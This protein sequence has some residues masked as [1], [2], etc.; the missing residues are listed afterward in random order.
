MKK[1]LF[2]LASLFLTGTLTAQ[3]TPHEAVAQMKRGINMG[4]TL[5][6]PY[7]DGWNN[8]PAEEY[9]FDL[10]KE[11]GFDVVRVPVR[12]HYHTSSVAPFSIDETWMN[13]VEEVVDWGLSR[14][15][16]VV[17]NA[18]HEEWIKEDYASATKRARFD[19]IWSQISVRFKDKSEKLI[20]E[21]INEPYGLSKVQNDELHQR[22]LSIIRRSN[23]TRNVIIQGHK[24][25]GSE[26]LIGMAIPADDYLIGSFH[27]YDPWPFGLEGTGTFGDPWQVQVLDQKFSDVKSWSDQ[28]N[29][30]VFLG[31]FGCNRL[32]DYNSRMNHYRTYVNLSLKYG[33][34][35]CAWDDGGS[36][37]ILFRGTG[38]WDEVKD[39]LIHCSPGSPTIQNLSIEQDSLIRI[40][41]SKGSGDHDSI[42]I[43]RRTGVEQYTRIAS[44]NPDTTS[45]LDLESIPNTYHH[46]RIIAH[47]N[48]GE[49]SHSHPQRIFL[50]EYIP[51]VR[52]Y[53]LGQAHQIPGTV[54]AEDFDTGGEG[55]AY[56]DMDPR[57]I[58][59][60]YRPDE[61]VDIY[62]RNGD[63]YHIGNALPGEWYEY[64]VMVE[65]EG[66]YFIDVHL[67][68]IEAHG[69]FLIAIGDKA[70]DTLEALNSNSWLYTE[71]VSF[72]MWLT[73]G[74]QIMRFTVIDQPL[75]NID[76]IDFA[77]NTT[78]INPFI[79]DA[80]DLIVFQGPEGD[81]L[82]PLPDNHH[83]EL[84]SM[85]SLSGKVI[86]SKQH[87]DRPCHLA[88]DGLEKGIYIIKAFSSGQVHSA[89]ILIR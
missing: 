11:A 71:K 42:F 30:P 31:E 45:F 44:L 23:P 10:Y 46:Y 35:S 69:K 29:I 36:F 88:T 84:V 65:Q 79:K 64:S 32:A 63:G 59:G 56:H 67:A 12:W 14:D 54:E 86:R 33:F 82:V 80:E 24:W 39:I 48:A 28:N 52:G 61:A 37:R 34:T 26:E 20:F 47:Y 55:L 15:L 81:V 75:F 76:K 3:I 68:A 13:R 77:L 22:V 51:K 89:K 5:E 49:V 60:A 83:T 18:H 6:P 8:P 70:S 43:E 16:Y 4:N 9:Y 21:I 66:E 50:K 19:S 72:S 53:F 40:K 2:L 73:E 62:D 38:A 57:N 41:W 58:A 7:E 78:G 87:P 85:Y 74:E 17:I 27:S 1:I 25:G